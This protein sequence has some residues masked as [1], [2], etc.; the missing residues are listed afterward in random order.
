[1]AS[2]TSLGL[3]QPSGLR[4]AIEEQILPANP[5]EASYRWI[6]DSGRDGQ[7]SVEDELLVTETAVI[8][9]RGRIVCKTFRFDNEKEQIVKA[10]LAYFPN[11]HST[12]NRNKAAKTASSSD[13][14]TDDEPLEKALVVFLKTQAHIYFLSGTSHIVHIPFEVEAA[15][16]GPVGVL[17]QR[18]RDANKPPA[19]LKFPRVPTNSFI[20]S[21]VTDF[22]SSQQSF[23]VDGVEPSSQKPLAIGLNSSLAQ[24]FEDPVTQTASQWPRLVSLMDPLLELGLVVTDHKPQTPRPKYRRQPRNSNFLDPAEQLLHVE[25]IPLQGA[26]FQEEELIIA[27]TVN[28]EAN[29]YSIWRLK[30]LE[31]EDP[32]VRKRKIL[33]EKASRRRSSIAPPY[34][35]TPATP[36]KPGLRESFGA[37]LP[38]KRQ[39]NSDRVE[40]PVDLVSSLEKHD[41]EGSAVTR[42]SSRRLSSMLARADLSASQE[43]SA[44]ADQ[45]T[46]PTTR[47]HDSYSNIHTRS[48]SGFGHQ[49]RGSLNSLLEAPLDV[50]LHEGFHNMGLDDPDFDGLQKDLL[51][52]RIYQFPLEKTHVHVTDPTS[53]LKNSQ[54]FTLCSPSFATN[55]HSRN[56]L[57]IGVQDAE[58]RRLNI[59]DL[60]IVLRRIPEAD[61]KANGRTSS[62]AITSADLRKAKNVVDSCKL[63]DDDHSAIL[64]LSESMDGRHELSTQAPWS[65]RTTL[66]PELVFVDD[67]RSLQYQGRK[68]DRDIKHRKS[69]VIDLLNGSIVGLRYPRSFG[70]VD[71]VDV[72]G[73]L[74]QLKIQLRPRN[75]QVGR[76]LAMCRNILEDA[77]GERI[78]G[79][80][81]HVMQ[82][83]KLQNEPLPDPEWSAVTILLFTLILNLGR[84]D[85]NAMQTARLPM[86]RR[87]NASGSF[88]SVRDMDD[89]K[90]MEAAESTNSLGCP[91]WMTNRG[92]QWALHEDADVTS[93]PSLD[94]GPVPKFISRHV[95]LTRDYMVSQQGAFAIGPNGYLPTSL[96]R[97]D[98][99]RRKT[100]EDILLALHL[101]LEEEKLDIMSPEHATSGRTDLRVVL[102]QLARW[103]RWHNFMAIYE[104]GIQE[105]VD[106]KY[107]SE[108]V[109]NPPIPAPATCPNILEWIQNRF[110][111]MRSQYRTPM[112]IYYADKQLSE[113]EKMLDTRWDSIVPRTM[114]FKRFFRMLKPTSSAVEMVE[115]MYH[116]GL[117]KYILQTLPEGVLVPLQDAITLCQPHPPHAWSPELLELVKRSDM[118]S[119]LSRNKPTQTTSNNLLVSLA[120]INK[121]AS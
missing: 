26:C 27:V 68:V 44:F 60:N 10:L 81:L 70:V 98:E 16:A 115:A 114:M 4:H 72:D 62:I 73:R 56:Q 54:V 29:L 79:G 32:F 18:K 48:S 7:Q 106:R 97:N 14:K 1:M 8:W 35:G 41:K 63:V 49:G 76:V 22:T 90:L 109:L 28:A 9:S 25:Q 88:G 40:K 85:S 11:S 24:L 71:A 20:S 33:K 65:E 42:R 117:T 37:P 52:S 94:D 112:D 99:S 93:S 59:V 13:R 58:E 95:G 45:P 92:W 120:F 34:L 107:D 5:P 46:I 61:Q 31:H 87:R 100:S 103:L 101:L 104:L 121:N 118:I 2:V 86:R 55:E 51:F 75:P 43:R 36:A 83:L 82:W 53:I 110:M 3:H 67:T 108:L 69:E 15:C 91:P 66:W 102:C 47:R 38:G 23:I 119:I 57:L 89:W 17:I 116:C 84:G 30:Y 6:I 19:A 74:H 105:D 50:D 78:H 96:A 80:W 111:G 77:N 64:I 113:D 12:A 21:Q 39:R